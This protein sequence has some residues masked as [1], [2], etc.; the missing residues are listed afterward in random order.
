[1]AEVLTDRGLGFESGRGVDWQVRNKE[2]ERQLGREHD[3]SAQLYAQFTY[4]KIEHDSAHPK[5]G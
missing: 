2:S 3:R 1:M 4:E 5:V